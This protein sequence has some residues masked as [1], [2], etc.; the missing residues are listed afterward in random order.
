MDKT[1]HAYRLEPIER[2]WNPWVRLAS[3]IY[4][5]TTGYVGPAIRVIFARAPRLLVGHLTLMAT[6]EYMI[7]LDRRTRSLVRVFGSR[8]NNCMYCD[9]LES[10]M[11]LRHKSL[12]Q[13]E[14]DAVPRFESSSLFTERERAALK[15]VEEVNTTR[16]ATDATFEA[17]RE[18]FSEKEIVE[19]TWVN[20]VNNYL[21]LQAKPLGIGSQ[22]YCPLPSPGRPALNHGATES[23]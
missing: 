7:S 8:I 6:A 14:I 17:L 10:H 9:D 18:H 3:F 22:G 20:A 16:V 15:Y 21:N 2:S 11:A 12:T 4:R 23:R 5:L 13:E 1:P 19:I